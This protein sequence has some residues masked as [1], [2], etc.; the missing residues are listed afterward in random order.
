MPDV[1]YSQYRFGTYRYDIAQ[2]L[3]FREDRLI[4]LAPKVS[5]TLLVL[6]E[7]H[8]NIVEKAELMRRIWPDTAVEEVGLARNISQLRKILG[9]EGESTEFIETLPKRGYRFV[10][11]VRVEAD[12]AGFPRRG[13]RFR[14]P[15]IRRFR[16]AMSAAILAVTT[17]GVYWQ[18]YRPSRY[19]L[20]GDGISEVAV[21]PFE[22]LSQE[23][24]CHTVSHEL[25]DLLLARLASRS[26]VHVLSPDTVSNYQHLHFSMS[27]MARILNMDAMVEGT[28]LRAGDEVR[29]TGRLIDVRSA[30]LIWSDSYDYPAAQLP[31][32][33]SRAA[34]QISA[35][36]TAH[37][38][39]RGHFL[40]NEP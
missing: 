2:R 8:G 31:E 12:T 5:E 15:F 26:H 3:L 27:V 38:T 33:E 1:F 39:L 32:A 37:L 6:V 10:A 23:L 9:S 22:C 24:N 7:N 17:V 13:A 16:F 21:V 14:R 19:Q 25:D 35:E 29:V 34:E 18:F 30:K 11:D 28:V 20:Q 40:A 36:V 4:P